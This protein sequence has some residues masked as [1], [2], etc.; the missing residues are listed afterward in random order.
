MKKELSSVI[1]AQTDERSLNML[2]DSHRPFLLRCA[3]AASRRH[4]SVNDDEWSVT[5]SAFVQAV[6]EYRQER[7]DFYAFA[8]L[9]IRR[10]L[11]DYFRSQ[12]RF[13]EEI[14]AAPEIFESGP[15]EDSPQ[16]ALQAAVSGKI[17][18]VEPGELKYEIEAANQAFS[19]YGF[20]F[21]DLAEC[22]PKA[23]KTRH[24]CAVAV[25]CVLRN[26]ELSAELKKT[27]Q[28]PAK[29]IQN[30]AKVPQKILERHRKYIIAAVE[31]LSGEYPCLAEYMRFIRKE[32]EQ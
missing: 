5:L 18:Q 26:A 9:V 23:Q 30:T 16:P 25:V 2:I 1:K 29:K 22:S 8:E 10:R 20:T 27:R 17:I 28:L 13:R 24:L 11:Y 7:G 4:I 15:L 6:Q 12:S 19:A 3:S 14:P 32:L 21:S 31:I